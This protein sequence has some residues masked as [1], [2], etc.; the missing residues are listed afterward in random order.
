MKNAKRIIFSLILTLVF[1]LVLPIRVMALDNPD[2]LIKKIAPD[3]KNAVFKVKNQ[4]V[5]KKGIF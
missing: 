5:L 2:D 1:S 3:G 4:Q